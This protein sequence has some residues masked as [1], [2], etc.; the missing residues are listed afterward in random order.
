MVCVYPV[1]FHTKNH[2]F[3]NFINFKLFWKEHI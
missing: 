3:L 2:L 1:S